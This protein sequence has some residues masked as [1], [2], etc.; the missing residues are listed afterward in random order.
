LKEGGEDLSAVETDNVEMN[1]YLEKFTL[2][3]CDANNPEVFFIKSNEDW[4]HINDE[5]KSIFCVAPGDYSSLGAIKLTTSGSAEKRRYIVLDNGNDLHPGKLNR[6]QLAKVGFILQDSNYWIID[7]M[8][9]WESRTT[10]HPI[11]I[12]NSDNNLINRYFMDNVGSGIYLYNGS[13]NNTIQNC[14]IQREDISIFYDRAAIGLD[15]DNRYNEDAIINITNTKII[16]NEVYNFVDGFQAIRTTWMEDGKRA[17][18]KEVNY[19][20]TVINGNHF[21]IDSTIYTD[22]KGNQ[23]PNGEC[24]YA[25]NAIDLKAGSNNPENPMII[26]HNLMWG[27]KESDKTN[28]YLSDPG[29]ALVV[30]YN[31][32][33]IIIKDNTIFNSTFGINMT[34]PLPGMLTVSNAIISNNIFDHIDNY[35]IGIVYANDISITNNLFIHQSKDNTTHYGKY[36]A[37]IEYVNNI[38]FNENKVYDCDD[39]IVLLRSL[40]NLTSKDNEYYKA[41]PLSSNSINMIYR[42]DPTKEYKDFKFNI[43]NF[44]NSSRELSLR[45]IIE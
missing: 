18:V 24:A 38:K 10:F 5:D 20:G 30:H 1:P 11:K 22:C 45:K 26:S 31:V 17:G 34:D 8:A 6:D 3:T 28:S 15:S 37:L 23:D 2:P 19:E 25:E 9:Y 33:N 43:N 29:V 13:D 42:A 21:Y 27:Y 35:S 36:W 32:D 16:N 14:R 44:T 39:K 40:E 7:R 4:S 12:I 41:L